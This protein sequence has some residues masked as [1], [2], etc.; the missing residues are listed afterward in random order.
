MV[1]CYLKKQMQNKMTMLLFCNLLSRYCYK[2]PVSIL[3]AIDAIAVSHGPG[4]YTG[5]RVGM[6]TA[7]GLCYALGKPLITVSELEML[8]KDII[9]NAGNFEENVLLLPHD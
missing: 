4:S 5:L 3:H 7:K 8:T 2:K 1:L 9:D 6:A